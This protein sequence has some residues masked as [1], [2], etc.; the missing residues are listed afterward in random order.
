[1]EKESNNI[2][3]GIALVIVIILCFWGFFGM[4]LGQGF[5][6]YILTSIRTIGIVLIVGLAVFGLFKTFID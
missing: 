6:G 4:M 3:C 2:G 1:M 5:F